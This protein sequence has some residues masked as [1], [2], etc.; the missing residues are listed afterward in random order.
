MSVTTSATATSL[1]GAFRPVT[2]TL[3]PAERERRASA[4]GHQALRAASSDFP[5]WSGDSQVKPSPPFT[6]V[7]PS[8]RRKRSGAPESADARTALPPR[9]AFV[10]H[11]VGDLALPE[12]I[13]VAGQ[14][15][16]HTDFAAVIPVG[17]TVPTSDMIGKVWL[18]DTS[19]DRMSA[20]H[21]PW[22]CP[23]WRPL[24]PHFSANGNRPRRQTH[25]LATEPGGSHGRGA[26]DRR[27]RDARL[28]QFLW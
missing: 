13:T 6:H 11:D 23:E 8:L 4:A 1:S 10:R 18:G 25:M 27:G 20:P 16:I 22:V 24:P 2:M 3:T 21:F 26:R 5:R 14:R 17:V 15:R 28:L 9:A 19:Q 12:G 7:T